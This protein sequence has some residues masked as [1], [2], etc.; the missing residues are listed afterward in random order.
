MR[1]KTALSDLRAKRYEKAEASLAQLL[2]EKGNSG[3]LHLAY[4]LALLGNGKRE[5][6]LEQCLEAADRKAPGAEEC[7]TD[8]RT[9][10]PALPAGEESLGQYTWDGRRGYNW[11][12]ATRS[13]HAEFVRVSPPTVCA[14]KQVDGFWV[15][16]YTCGGDGR[17]FQWSFDPPFAG[18]SPM[19]IGLG[20]PL[21]ELKER[22]GDGL[23]QGAG[24]CWYG[25]T[26]RL[27]AQPSEDGQS[28]GRILVSR[29]GVPHLVNALYYL[30][31]PLE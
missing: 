20:T 21:A 28:V 3:T 31:D 23:R 19:G 11:T 8:L 27:C 5:L 24:L 30:G 13:D 14:Y 4:A 29:R 10:L 9:D 2:A 26:L 12:G 22:W 1:Y 17:V 25:H 7:V 16:T 15:F 18:K 6:A